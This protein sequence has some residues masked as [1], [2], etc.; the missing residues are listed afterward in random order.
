[1]RN[2]Q[3]LPAII[4]RPLA[5][6]SLLVLAA[7]ILQAVSAQVVVYPVPT[8]ETN[9][10]DYQ[11][12]VNGQPVFCY[13]SYELDNSSTQTE[14]GR[15]VDPLTFASFDFQGTVTVTVSFGS[16]LTNAGI[17][18][19]TVTIRPLASGLKPS[20]SSSNTVT[21]QLS[22]P[23]QLSIEPGGQTRRP[24]H[25]FANPLEIN[26]PVPTN[27]N[28]KALAPGTHTAADV[29]LSGSQS[30][31]YFEPGVHLV[32]SIS[33]GNGETVYVAGGAVVELAPTNNVTY[34][35]TNYGMAFADVPP[36]INAMWVNN[37][38]I[39]GRGI[40]SGRVALENYQRAK[41]IRAQG[42][43]N[44]TIE[45]VTLR[46]PGDWTLDLIN[47]SHGEVENVKVVANF[48]NSDGVAVGGTSHTT[49]Q[50]SFCHNA[51]DAFEVKGW[52]PMTDVTFS[53]CVCWSDVGICFGLAWDVP[54]N[55]SNVWFQNCT[56]IHDL[57]RTT[58]QPAVGMCVIVDPTTGVTNPGSVSGITFQNIVIEDVTSALI[59]PLKVV[60]N[61]SGGGWQ[62]TTGGPTLTKNPYVRLNPPACA[63][64]VGPIS[65][66]IFNNIQVLHSVNP[67]IAVISAG[68]NAPINNVSF[69]NVSINGNPVASV[70]DPRIYTNQWVYG[71]TM[72]QRALQPIKKPVF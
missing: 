33:P 41:L 25:L 1:M 70:S 31:L 49:V 30:V 5:L 26:A 20:V 63:T 27:A 37:L 72:T 61:W 46:E 45:G 18:T 68:P 14:M 52:I 54:C 48:V 23:C 34:N 22:Q 40:L 42:L 10:P 57:G 13:T 47:S 59:A 50:D 56:V 32:P 9:S 19:S 44:F 15:P 55:V 38:T 60:N 11:V 3:K 65:N 53:N 8:G 39:R 7:L 24:L 66:V 6:K 12:W 43:S 29:T 67:D 36:L 64:N 51:D 17:N 16:S 4:L 35:D 69:N 2:N 62:M 28:V 58:A 71:L 21:F